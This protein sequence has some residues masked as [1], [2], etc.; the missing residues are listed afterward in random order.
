[1]SLRRNANRGSGGSRGN[2]RSSE[3]DVALVQ[4]QIAAQ[5]RNRRWHDFLCGKRD[6]LQARLRQQ[7]YSQRPSGNVQ[8]PEGCEAAAG[9]PALEGAGRLKLPE[10]TRGYAPAV[11]G[12]QR[13]PSHTAGNAAGGSEGGIGCEGC[14]GGEGDT[15]DHGDEVEARVPAS[16]PVNANAGG[17]AGPDMSGVTT[18]SG[19]TREA[20]VPCKVLCSL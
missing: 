20:T 15:A 19:G 9:L 14:E 2:K 3:R 12:E 4:M 7:G 10:Q 16:R 6:E 5:A 13:V 1:M 11:S 18:S 17:A 8:L